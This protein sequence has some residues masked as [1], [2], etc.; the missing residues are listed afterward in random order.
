MIA[1]TLSLKLRS[2]P[3]LPPVRLLIFFLTGSRA[4]LL[5]IQPFT[6]Q[7]ALSCTT[8]VSMLSAYCRSTAF[9]AHCNVSQVAM[10]GWDCRMMNNEWPEHA[11]PSSSPAIYMPHVTPQR[12]NAVMS[13]AYGGKD[14]A[15]RLCVLR[16]CAIKAEGK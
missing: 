12:S 14:E 10:T 7:S 1:W 3:L 8:S 15:D 9:R 2:R 13:R 16:S 6:I 5:G 4:A 11:M